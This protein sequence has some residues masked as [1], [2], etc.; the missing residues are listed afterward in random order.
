MDMAVKLYADLRDFSLGLNQK[1]G[2]TLIMDQ[3]LVDAE[4]AVLGKGFVQKRYGYEVFASAPIQ[5]TLYQW[6][7]F[8]VKKW[9]EV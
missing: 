5:S 8:G 6:N 2:P 3:E 1:D 4:N 9:S 7:Q